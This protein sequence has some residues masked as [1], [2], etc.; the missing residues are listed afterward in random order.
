VCGRCGAVSLTGDDCP[1]WG[2]AASPIP[3]LLEEMTARVLDD[4]G[5]VVAVHGPSGAAAARLRFPVPQG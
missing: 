3:D 2:A 4:D 5:E 1:D